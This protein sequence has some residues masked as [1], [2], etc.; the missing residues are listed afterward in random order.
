MYLGHFSF[1]DYAAV[2]VNT[3]QGDTE[4]DSVVFAT[5]D[6]IIKDSFCLSFDVVL[7]KRLRIF[8]QYL[9]DSNKA[10]RWLIYEQTPRTT[11][12]L[13]YMLINCPEYYN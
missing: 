5:K 4:F 10:Q 9:G 11:D 6:I 8:M 12:Y 13:K 2:A 1:A 3:E 7:M